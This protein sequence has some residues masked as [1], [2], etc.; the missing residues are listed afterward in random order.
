MN[1]QAFDDY[2]EKA[3]ETCPNCH[4]SFNPQAFKRHGKICSAERPF[5]PLNKAKLDAYK[6]KRNERREQE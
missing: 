6:A 1:V 3:L 5:N 4:R 2:N